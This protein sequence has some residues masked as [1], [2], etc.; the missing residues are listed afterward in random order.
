GELELGEFSVHLL[1]HHLLHEPAP[2]EQPDGVVDVV[3]QE[4][5]ARPLVPVL[6]VLLASGAMERTSM[7]AERSL[8]RGMRTMEPRSMAEALIWL[9]A[10]KWGS[11]RRYELTLELSTRQISDAL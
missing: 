5:G 2:L 1:P 7:R 4:A 10:S 6:L 8:P 9:G 3:R 11:R